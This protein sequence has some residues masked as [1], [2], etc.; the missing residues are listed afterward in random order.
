MCLRR[1]TS[2]IAVLCALAL[3]AFAADSAAAEQRAYVCALGGSGFSDAHCNVKGGFLYG[4]ELIES[5]T[6]VVGSNLNTANSTSTAATSNL[7]GQIAGVITEI[8]CTEVGASGSISNEAFVETWAEGIIGIT[9]GG[10]SVTAPGGR[11]CLV[12]GGKITTS[13]LAPTTRFQAAGNVKIVPFIG[14]E[15]ASVRIKGCAGE[16]PPA[17]KY[18]VTG[19]FVASASGATL[20][21]THAKVTEQNTLKFAGAKAGIEGALTLE[22]EFSGDGIAFT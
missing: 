13:T 2:A 4:H 10:C 9:Y 12:E 17:G 20:T 15:L 18:P 19:S 6:L 22:E 14:T 3:S 7:R 21:T 8:R 5:P 11:G 1:S 16:A